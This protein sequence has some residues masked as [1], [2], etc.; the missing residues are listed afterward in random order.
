MKKA[1]GR[2]WLRPLLFL[3]GG[4]L[5]GLAYYRLFGCA[6]GCAIASTPWRSMLYLAALG[7]LAGAATQRGCRGGCSM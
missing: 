4:A 1:E 3:G 7:W 6:G 5:A 2:R